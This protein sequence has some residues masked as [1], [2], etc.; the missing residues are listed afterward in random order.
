[1]THTAFI[2]VGNMGGPMARNLAKSGWTVKAFD[3]SPEAMQVAAEGGTIPSQSA[4]QAVQGATTVVTMLPEG[5]HVKAAYM[6]EGGI[7]THESNALR[8]IVRI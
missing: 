3:V 7:F 4:A 8:R 2:G 6:G 5:K 1:M